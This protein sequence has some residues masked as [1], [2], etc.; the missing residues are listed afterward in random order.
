MEITK[1][2]QA[3]PIKAVC[4]GPEGIGK[5]T[6]ASQWPA[7]LFVDVENGTSSLDVNRTPQPT[8]WTMLKNIVAELTKNAQ[9]FQTLVIDTAD[10]AD[11]LAATE[12]CA[13]WNKDSI[14]QINF[15]KGWLCMADK[16]AKLLDLLLELQKK[17]GMHVLFLA[18]STIRKFEQPDEAGAYDRYELKMEK[19]SSALLKEWADMLLFANY[20]TLVIDVEGKKKAQGGKRVMYTAHHS[21]WDAK[22]RFGLPEELPF[23]FAGIAKITNTEPKKEAPKPEPVKPAEPPKAEA[24]KVEPPKQEVPKTEP[25]IPAPSAPAVPPAP[26][27]KN[28]AFIP[29]CIPKELRDLMILSGVTVD[30]LKATCTKSYPIDTP[31]ENYDPNFFLAKIVPSWEKVVALVEKQ[32]AIK[33]QA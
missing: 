24:P 25:V 18:H 14:G 7:P 5:S 19:K 33:K 6:F 8:S 32:R 26:A 30:E 31:I 29:P 13:E 16:W 2:K 12:V 28:E 11:N 4:Y 21:S 20:K 27:V 15:G 1:G 17:Q 10:W 9:G 3:K 23:D 22:N